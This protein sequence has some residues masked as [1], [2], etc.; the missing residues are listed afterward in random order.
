MRRHLLAAIL[1]VATGA[2]LAACAP[3][4]T[5]YVP[6]QAADRRV[7]VVNGS[8]STVREFYASNISRNSWEEDILGQDV[9]L[10]GRSVSI[11]IDDGSG[12]CRFDFRAILAD[13]RALEQRDVN[14]C[15][16][17]RYVIR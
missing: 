16:I 5:T 15:Q 14:V 8:G 3:A 13:G 4:S 11:N 17:S 1:M 6:V 7:Q 10:P 9:L 12:A 2:G